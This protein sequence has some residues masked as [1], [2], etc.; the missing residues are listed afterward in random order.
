MTDADTKKVW[1]EIRIFESKE[2][3]RQLAAERLGFALPAGQ[4]EEVP[5]CFQPRS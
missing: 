5:A 3:L 2:A 1:Q 4:A